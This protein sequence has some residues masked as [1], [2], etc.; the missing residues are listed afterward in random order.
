MKVG[1]IGVGNVGTACAKAMLL[2][3]SCHEIV[4][5]DL[6]ERRARGVAT[7]LSHGELLCPPTRIRTG[8]YADLADAAVVVI[9]AGINEQAGQAT[10]R[11]DNLGRLRLLPRNAGIYRDIVPRIAEVAPRAPILVVTDP[12]D[13]LADVARRLTATNP[14]LSSGTFLDTLR[15]RL[16]VARR[17]G[18]HP[19]SVDA[20]VIGEHGTSQVYVWS[21]A[22]IGGAPVLELAAREGRDAAGFR[23]E[24]EDAVRY[25]NIDIIK[26]TGASQHGIGIVTARIVEAMRRYASGEL[27]PQPIPFKDAD[28]IVA[29]GSDGMMNAVRLARHGVLKP[30]LKPDHRALGSINSPMQCMMKEICAQCLQPQVDPATGA[31]RIV[32]SCFCQDQPLDAVDFAA[33]A[34]RLSQNS[35][36]EK[37]TAQWI[38]RCL[39]RLGARENAA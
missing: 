35:V 13:A 30:W 1:I 12:P 24:I 39:V 26:G 21:S 15:F 31:R 18:C 10:D 17:L 25:A 27:G 36:Q 2:R 16:Q 9:T 33:L 8:G 4:L 23:A 20:L 34:H 19:S 38:D 28:R 5:L 22:Q 3:G 11:T 7:D 14:I 37:L 6:D 32:F 29:I